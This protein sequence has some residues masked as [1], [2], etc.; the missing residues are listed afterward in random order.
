MAGTH[1]SSV[2]MYKVTDPLNNTA[3]DIYE[4][5]REPRLRQTRA[6]HRIAQEIRLQG[7]DH[8]ICC[9]PS[10]VLRL[11]RDGYFEYGCER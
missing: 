6:R 1:S 9:L 11:L 3:F 10:C 8:V 2:T 5:V 4:Y 7:H